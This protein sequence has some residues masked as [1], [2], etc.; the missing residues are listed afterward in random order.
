MCKLYCW[1]I[2]PSHS[3]PFFNQ[4]R[5]GYRPVH[6]WFLIIASVRECL[7]VYVCMC[8]SAPEAMNN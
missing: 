6:A 8:V 7:Y 2:A 1:N 4:G 5:A 3:F